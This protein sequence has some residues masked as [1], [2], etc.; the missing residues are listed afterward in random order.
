M[1][2]QSQ[3]DARITSQTRVSR[4]KD[5]MSLRRASKKV[6]CNGFEISPDI[7]VPPVRLS[8]RLPDTS[9]PFRENPAVLFREAFK[10]FSPARFC[11]P[12]LLSVPQFSTA[13]CPIA[14]ENWQIARRCSSFSRFTRPSF[15]GCFLSN[16]RCFECV[17]KIAM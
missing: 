16:E 7:R 12:R 5:K 13:A 8:D 9:F 6:L 14:S 2:L 1:P 10:R 17:V 4:T 15:G 3:R 11:A